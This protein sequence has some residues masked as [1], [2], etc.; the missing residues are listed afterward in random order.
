ME[1]CTLYVDSILKSDL[2][3]TSDQADKL[4]E[5]VKEKMK[6]VDLIKL[7]FSKISVM[8]SNFASTLIWKLT[9]DNFKENSIQFTGLT[10][11]QKRLLS[12]AKELSLQKT[13]QSTDNKFPKSKEEIVSFL[14]NENSIAIRVN[15][16]EEVKE[17]YKFI[18]NFSRKTI[19]IFN[20]LLESDTWFLSKDKGNEFL[21]GYG[22]LS[23]K[24]TEKFIIIEPFY[25]ESDNL[26][27]NSI[28]WGDLS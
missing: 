4:F 6:E 3:T 2:A 28:S 13:G 14:S 23:I 22:Y 15:S 1:I 5:I 11:S 8:V 26:K 7:N 9:L 12:T 16:V 10:E 19:S 24:P 25:K 17:A 21:L 27:K 18:K 20:E